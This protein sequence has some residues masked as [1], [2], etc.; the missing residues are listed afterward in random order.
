MSFPMGDHSTHIGF[1]ER[2]HM[3]AC[4]LRANHVLRN[5]ATHCVQRLDGPCGGCSL[6]R[7]LLRSEYFLSRPEKLAGGWLLPRRHWLAA[8]NV[9]QDVFL[10]DPPPR[11]RVPGQ[12]RRRAPPQY[13]Q[14]PEK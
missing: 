13:V 8:F 9:G 11:S 12:D 4:V 7:R 2:R 1:H 6:G 14:R 10:R 5:P 3:R